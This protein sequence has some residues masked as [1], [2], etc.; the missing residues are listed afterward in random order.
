MAVKINNVNVKN[1]K[2]VVKSVAKIKNVAKQ[3]ENVL[4]RLNAA[5]IRSV[6]KMVVARKIIAI[7]QKSNAA[8]VV[9][10]NFSQKT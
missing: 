3:M 2:S 6:V 7:A 4:V 5:K 1:V 10:N 9:K 8:V